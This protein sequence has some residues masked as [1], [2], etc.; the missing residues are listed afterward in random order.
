MLRLSTDALDRLFMKQDIINMKLSY[1]L[2][3]HDKIDDKIR[4]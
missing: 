4:T 3:Y 2:S 1:H